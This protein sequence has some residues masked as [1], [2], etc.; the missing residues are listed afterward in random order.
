MPLLQESQQNEQASP[1]VFRAGLLSRT[2]VSSENVGGDVADGRRRSACHSPCC[3][4]DGPRG[5]A[6]SDAPS[7]KSRRHVPRTSRSDGGKA[8]GDTSGETHLCAVAS[9]AF[10]RDVRE[11]SNKRSADRG[12]DAQPDAR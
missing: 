8:S 3:D 9:V 5:G 4:S 6:R 11:H 1:E 10:R 7:D 12:R 2:E